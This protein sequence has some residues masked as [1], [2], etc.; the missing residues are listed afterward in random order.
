[1]AQVAQRRFIILNLCVAFFVNCLDGQDEHGV[2]FVAPAVV[3]GFF[4]F[5]SKV[6]HIFLSL[7]VKIPFYP[8]AWRLSS[9]SLAACS[10]Y[11]LF[12]ICP[13]RLRRPELKANPSLRQILP[14]HHWK[15]YSSIPYIP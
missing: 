2:S 14:I 8:S 1:M 7:I 12:F 15:L 13:G 4:V 10:F 6:G 9:L 11:F 5:F 3:S